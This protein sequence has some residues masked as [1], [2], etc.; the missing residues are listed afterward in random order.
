MLT[1]SVI[2]TSLVYLQ[3]GSVKKSKLMKLMKLVN[4]DEVNLH[5]FQTT[6]GN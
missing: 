1:S 6:W 3:Q 4:V 5:I 2:Q